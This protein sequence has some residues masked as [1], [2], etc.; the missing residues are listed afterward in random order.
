MVWQVPKRAVRNFLADD[1]ITLAAALAFYA[2]LSLAPLLVLTLTV[3]GFMGDSTQQR[4]IAQTQNLIG[5]QAGQ[6]LE[7]LLNNAKAQR[8]G[9]TIS[10]IVGLAVLILSATSVFGQLQYSLSRIFNV[11]AKRGFVKGWLSKRLTS[12]LMVFGIG[13]VVLASIVVSS[14]ISFTF[15]GSGPAA[16]I[17]NLVVSL[18]VFTAIFMIMFRILPDIRITWKNTVVG[19]IISSILFVVGMWA[20]GKYLGSSGTSSV[21][22][23][24]GSL[25][26]LLLWIY[27]SSIILF[28]GAE[29]T[30]AYAQC[31]GIEI[32]PNEFAE[33]DPEAAKTHQAPQREPEPEPAHAGIDS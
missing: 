15:R 13:V 19:A 31:C 7:L 11:R 25:V 14:V 20:I 29:L 12:L 21:Y 30:Q 3:L 24:A 23:A 32:V 10:A 18:L 1:A 27:Y 16:Q 2:M 8:V 5:P 4:V 28:L 17:I 9:A 6:G 33:W 22:G 26:V